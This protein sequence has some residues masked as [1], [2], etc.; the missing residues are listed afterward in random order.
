[1]S[2]H[3]LLKAWILAC[4]VIA[5]VPARADPPPVVND[6][7]A[8]AAQAYEQRVPVFVAFTL[9]HCPYCN[10]ARREYWKPMNESTEWRATVRM[11]EVMLDGE[12]AFRDF[13]GNATTVR[14]FARRFNVRST[15]TVIVFDASGTPAAEPIVGLASADFYGAYLQQAVERGLARMRRTQ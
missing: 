9:K 6:L 7:A 4:V 2:T 8:V 13:S 14:E 11:V 5:T 12:Q 3:S 10:S 1:L 15:P